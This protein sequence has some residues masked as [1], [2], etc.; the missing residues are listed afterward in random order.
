MKKYSARRVGLGARN[1][2][3]SGGGRTEVRA[4]VGLRRCRSEATVPYR[5]LGVS[6]STVDSHFRANLPA[7]NPPLTPTAVELRSADFSP[8]PPGTCKSAG[9]GMNSALQVRRNRLN[10]TASLV[11]DEQLVIFGQLAVEFAVGEAEIFV[12]EFVAVGDDVLVGR[13]RHERFP[14]IGQHW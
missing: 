6:K 4:P 11:E 7:T 2:F 13:N 14:A 5:R 10:S 12:I 3:R 1:L 8:P 9:S